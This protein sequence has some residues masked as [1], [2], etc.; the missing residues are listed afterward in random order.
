MKRTILLCSILLCLVGIVLAVHA[1]RRRVPK[2][3]LRHTVAFNFKPDVSQEMVEKILVDTKATLPTIKGAANI[4]V[5][6]Q[7]SRWTKYQYGISIDFINLEAKAAYA[8]SPQSM[9][10]HEQYKPYVEDEVVIDIVNE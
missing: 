7:T 4:V 6:R 5:G 10:L 1:E 2:G 3:I 8:K 9:R